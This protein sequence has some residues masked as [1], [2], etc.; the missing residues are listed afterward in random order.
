MLAADPAGGC[1]L[2]VYDGEQP[3]SCRIGLDGDVTDAMAGGDLLGIDPVK[4]A[5]VHLEDCAEQNC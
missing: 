3:T 2:V 1:T 5:I 4:E